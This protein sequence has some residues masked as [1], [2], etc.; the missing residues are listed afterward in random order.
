M[1]AIL[2]KKGVILSDSASVN[3]TE[4]LEDGGKVRPLTSQFLFAL[5]ANSE[6]DWII[7]FTFSNHRK[8]SVELMCTIS[9]CAHNDA[10]RI[11]DGGVPETLGGWMV[12]NIQSMGGFQLID[13]TTQ[14]EL[15]LIGVNNIHTIQWTTERAGEYCSKPHKTPQAFGVDAFRNIMR[16]VSEEVTQ[17]Q[18][19]HQTCA[20]HLEVG[21]RIYRHEIRKNARM[22][23][24]FALVCTGSWHPRSRKHLATYPT[25][26]VIPPDLVE[27]PRNT[28]G[29]VLGDLTNNMSAKV[30]GIKLPLDW[31][32]V[33]KLWTAHTRA[34]E[35]VT[36][37]PKAAKRSKAK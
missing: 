18:A 36:P 35:E 10:E 34:A 33:L 8:N 11:I 6:P 27:G 15:I 14:F 2:C 28:D 12:K 22:A 19:M 13:E 5:D 4:W 31:K 1:T 3:D 30:Q 26:P 23:S 16:M 20:E 17:Q 9:D 29:C 24:G 37:K 21:G 32:L 25:V 7:G